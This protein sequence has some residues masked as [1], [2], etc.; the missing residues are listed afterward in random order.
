VIP[1]EEE[2]RIEICGGIKSLDLGPVGK[3]MQLRF[4]LYGNISLYCC[5][6]ISSVSFLE[7]GEERQMTKR[8]IYYVY[9]Q[10]GEGLWEICKK[11]GVSPQQVC[12]ENH[13]EEEHPLP[14]VIRL[15]R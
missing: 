14:D 15:I 2:C 10:W 9:P 6:K 12:K 13:M 3:N 4:D 5:E 1:K 7:E 8:G 11:Y